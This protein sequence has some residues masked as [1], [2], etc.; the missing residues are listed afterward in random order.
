MSV[1]EPASSTESEE[2]PRRFANLAIAFGLQ[3]N[4]SGR[5]AFIWAERW[6]A[7]IL[8][9][10]VAIGTPL[11]G[12]SGF[13]VETKLWLLVGWL[14]LYL[15]YMLLEGREILGQ[16]EGRGAISAPQARR[17]VRTAQLPH[18][19]IL[20]AIFA[21]AFAWAYY[22]DTPGGSP[23][24]YGWVE[25]TLLAITFFAQMISNYMFNGM[26]L[27]LSKSAPRGERSER[28]LPH[29]TS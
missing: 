20:L 26:V 14:V 11:L 24:V 15:L 9:V 19:G 4:P 22:K 6:N 2:K 29:A 23:I 18:I 3:R 16:M 7:P 12:W 28:Q 21:W 1:H 17:Q 10:L 27:E 8:M 13:A 5:P 25:W